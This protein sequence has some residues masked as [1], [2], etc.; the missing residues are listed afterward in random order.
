VAG[1]GFQDSFE[2]H[3]A[4]LGMR[5]SFGQSGGDGGSNEQNIPA[6][7][8]LE[9]VKAFLRGAF[10][11]SGGEGIL[12]IRLNQVM[13]FG[14]GVAQAE[15]KHCF[16]ISKVT[17]NVANGPF[18]WRRPLFKFCFA[19]VADKLRKAFWSCRN[20]CQRLF[21]LQKMRRDL[22]DWLLPPLTASYKGLNN[23]I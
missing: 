19:C 1:H 12:I 6:P 20:Y 17:Q 13:R 3:G 11:V 10:L 2:G 18:L 16:R 23:M 7:D 4:A 5:D 14:D 15:G 22:V 8:G 9:G 21:A